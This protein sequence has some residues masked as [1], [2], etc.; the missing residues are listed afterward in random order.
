MSVKVPTMN[1]PETC[2]ECPFCYGS[3]RTWCWV[4]NK[5][6]D[7]DFIRAQSYKD[8]DC[9]LID[10]NKEHKT[11]SGFIFGIVVLLLLSIFKRRK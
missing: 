8:P 1:I 6:L 3:M 4:T 7:G 10:D 2:G 11:L 9:P 5:K